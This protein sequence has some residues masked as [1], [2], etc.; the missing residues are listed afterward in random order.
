MTL[1]ARIDAEEMLKTVLKE[2]VAYVPG[3]PFFVNAQGRNTLRLCF[4]T[5]STK[6]IEEGIQRLSSVIKELAT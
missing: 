1:P 5:A 6:D 3:K 2:N 4:A